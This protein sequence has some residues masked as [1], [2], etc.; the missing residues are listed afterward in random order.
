MPSTFRGLI[1]CSFSSIAAEKAS[2]PSDPTSSRARLSRPGG[3]RGRRQH[4]DVVAA[5]AAQLARKARGDLLGLGR[6]E[7]AQALDQLGDVRGHL[8]AEIV[9]ERSRNDAACR[10]PGSR[11][12]RAR[13][14]P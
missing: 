9:R 10:R 14:R 7:R 6:A 8:G 11:R 2:V 13:C 4:V 3:A 1:G 5:D 12:S